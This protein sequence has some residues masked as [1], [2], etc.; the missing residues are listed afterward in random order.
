MGLL[1]LIMASYITSYAQ[2]MFPSN[3]IITEFDD[4][5]DLLNENTRR[6]VRELLLK[7]AHRSL[8]MKITIADEFNM[9]IRARVKS[10]IE[11]LRYGWVVEAEAQVGQSASIC[12]STTKMLIRDDFIAEFR[13]SMAANNSRHYL[14]VINTDALGM[15]PA[16]IGALLVHQMPGAL[17]WRHNEITACS[18]DLEQKEGDHKIEQEDNTGPWV[19]E[20][21]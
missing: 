18:L 4:T 3:P 7:D 16:D 1:S 2:G 21:V 14:L 6:L 5:S 19:V 10:R 9:T 12:C 17:Y 8:T 20:M 13:F 11:G 15:F